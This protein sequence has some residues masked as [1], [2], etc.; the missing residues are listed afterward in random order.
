[1]PARSP[2]PFLCRTFTVAPP[3]RRPL[4]CPCSAKGWAAPA[5]ASDE[6]ENNAGDSSKPKPEGSANK[7]KFGF[8]L[9]E[10]GT[11]RVDFLSQ[12]FVCRRRSRPRR[13]SGVGKGS[14]SYCHPRISSQSRRCTVHDVAVGGGRGCCGDDAR[15]RWTSP[16]RLVLNGVGAVKSRPVCSAAVRL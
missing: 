9:R 14:S 4:R 16:C 1:M 10:R 12:G 11:H 13:T 15:V 3:R 5:A 8:R 6:V 7:W 2:P